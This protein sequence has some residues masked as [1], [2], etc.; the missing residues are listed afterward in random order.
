[1]RLRRV[2]CAGRGRLPGCSHSESAMDE[3]AYALRVDPIVLRLTNDAALDQATGKPW[4]AK[5]LREC[6]EQSADRF[7]WGGT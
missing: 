7:G 3:L 6:F 1:M 5:H 2:S 4:S